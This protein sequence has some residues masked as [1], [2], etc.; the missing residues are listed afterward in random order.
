MSVIQI[1]TGTM[2]KCVQKARQLVCDSDVSA[3]QQIP[4]D[5]DTDNKIDKLST[6]LSTFLPYRVSIEGESPLSR[7][8]R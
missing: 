8:K 7:Y 6:F 1:M 4:A 2:D 5:I 3:I